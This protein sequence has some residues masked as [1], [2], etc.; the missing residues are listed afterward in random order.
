[1]LLLADKEVKYLILFIYK[2][3][4]CCIVDSFPS[5]PKRKKKNTKN[6]TSPVFVLCGLNCCTCLKINPCCFSAQSPDSV[7]VFSNFYKW[8]VVTNPPVLIIFVTQVDKCVDTYR[9]AQRTAGTP[10]S[11]CWCQKRLLIN[12][13]SHPDPGNREPVLVGCGCQKGCEP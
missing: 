1:M 5:I 9:W 4:W 12:S 8:G 7:F 2:V 11:S 13:E 10:L 3:W 6:L